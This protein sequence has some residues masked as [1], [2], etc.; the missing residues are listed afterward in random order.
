[1]LI[2]KA[3][4]HARTMRRCRSFNVLRAYQLIVTA[5]LKFSSM[6]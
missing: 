1:M 4:R 6:T 3:G 5:P 2:S